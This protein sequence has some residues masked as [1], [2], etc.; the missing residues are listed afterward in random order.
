MHIWLSPEN[1]K[2][3]IL[4]IS[5]TLS[6][7]DNENS[8]RYNHNAIKAIN[9]IDQG[10]KKIAQE[11]DDFKNKKYIV[12]HDAYQYFEKY[13][14]LRSPS[15]ILSIEE[16][17]YLGM[18]SLMKLKKIMKKENIKCIISH[19]QEDSINPKNFSKDT[20]M[21]MLDPIG[22]NT[23]LGQNAYLVLISKIAKNF[24]SC[25]GD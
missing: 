2:L 20:K 18:K 25:F 17:S 12:T 1:A 19:S 11:L 14:G 9:E 22:S 4:F 5:E 3:M 7:I 23:E 16:D 24:K 21:K 6:K 15:I 13:F 10:V 8:H